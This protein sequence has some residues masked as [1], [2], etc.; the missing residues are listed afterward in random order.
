MGCLVWGVFMSDQWVSRVDSNC[1]RTHV[2]RLADTSAA[3][4][5][6]VH[7]ALSPTMT[8]TRHLELPGSLHVSHAALATHPGTDGGAGGLSLVLAASSGGRALLVVIQSGEAVDHLKAS[9]LVLPA[10]CT[11]Y[12]PSVYRCVCRTRVLFKHPYTNILCVYGISP[13]SK[14]TVYMHV[15]NPFKCGSPPG[16]RARARRV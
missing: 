3:L 4:A 1:H 9:A 11:A 6:S 15:F 8:V 12:Q 10:G 14:T 5:R 7:D 2:A 13:L 16:T